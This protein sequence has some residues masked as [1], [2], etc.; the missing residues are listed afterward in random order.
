MSTNAG[1]V[2]FLGA[3][4]GTGKAFLI[5][6]L[7][8]KIRS[9]GKI[10]LAAASSGIAATLLEGGKTAHAAIK[11]PLNMIHQETPVCKSQNK[12]IY[13]WCLKNAS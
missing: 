11:L 13:L 12:V 7:V 8:A 9:K 6:L 5:S 2:L 1:Q 10:C 4:G 3:P